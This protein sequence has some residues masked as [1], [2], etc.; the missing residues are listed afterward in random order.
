MLLLYIYSLDTN[1]ASIRDC[2]EYLEQLQ[3]IHRKQQKLELQPNSY[4][5]AGESASKD[6]FEEDIQLE[7]VRDCFHEL[8]KGM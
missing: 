8:V 1:K 3:T 4:L 5:I 2:L 6:V 7:D